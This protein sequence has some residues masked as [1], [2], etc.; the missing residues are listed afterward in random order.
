MSTPAS[1]SRADRLV[2]LD[3]ARFL[4][5]IGMMATH[6]W[7]YDISTGGD[8]PITQLLSGKAAAL[9]AVLAG[10]GIVLTSRRDLAAGSPAAA[11]LNL[12]GRGFTLLVLGLTLGVIPG[13]IYVIIAYYGVTF[14][15]AIP[16]V[17]W[18][19]RTLLIVAGIWAIVWP[20]CSQALRM[21]LDGVDSPE[22]GSASWFDVA[23]GGFARGL[24][25]TGVYPALTWIVYVLVG[26]AIGRML[27]DARAGGTL[28]RFALLLAAI[29]LGVAIAA[30]RIAALLL[31]PLG[32]VQGIA[33]GMTGGL[34]PDPTT[35][36]AVEDALTEGMYG[37]SPADSFW[38]LV[39][40]SPHSGTTLDLVF[41][42]GIAAVVIGLC[43]ALGT[44]LNRGWSRVLMPA[45]GAGAAPLTVYSAHV[46]MASV[47][48]LIAAIGLGITEDKI[49]LISSP[50]LWALH[51]AG[52][53][54]LGWIIALTRRRGPL[55]TLVHASGRA[56][57]RLGA[58]SVAAPAQAQVQASVQPP[59]TSPERPTL[60]RH[61]DR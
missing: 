15:L 46:F 19:P 3:L 40:R 8:T 35:I 36:T 45:T 53:L 13:G 26:M 21:P 28:R 16:A 37:T 41:T 38:W 43:L 39:A 18:R 61:P 57:A 27:M 4:A 29:G 34:D 58:G 17:T 49:W 33:R 6:V 1:R 7:A 60:P 55:E 25:I 54:L 31:G 51:V 44:V 50:Q 14:W 24:L 5:L 2:G 48:A 47:G 30:D 42:I 59:P 23:T 11:R 20:I 56:L 9:F 22:I 32:G 10:I 12:F 52:A